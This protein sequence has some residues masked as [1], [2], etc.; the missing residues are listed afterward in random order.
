M[1]QDYVSGRRSTSA[2]DF[3]VLTSTLPNNQTSTHTKTGSVEA[4]STMTQQPYTAVIS[5][6][7]VDDHALMREGLRKIL[8]LE[9]D[10]HIIGEAINGFDALHKIRQLRPDVL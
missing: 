10:M 3:P 4:Q 1:Q 9:Q 7:L 2:I 8:E 6:L 5:I